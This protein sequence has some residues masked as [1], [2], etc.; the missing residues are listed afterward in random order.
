MENTIR[1]TYKPDS[2][3]WEKLAEC[4]KQAHESN[5]AQGINMQCAEFTGIELRDA[6]KNGITLVAQDDAGTLAGMLSVE[7]NKVN[8]WW[9]KGLGAY[10]CYVAV[11]PEF[12]G[13]GVYRALSE[14]A[15][16]IIASKGISVEYL[17]THIKNEAAQRAYIKDGYQKVRFSPGSGTDYYSVEM[18]KWLDG[19]GK[20]RTLCCL[21]YTAIEIAVRIV[22][23]PGKIRRFLL[24]L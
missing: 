7:F 20:S 17:N 11:A 8:R 5:K 24:F 16:E 6:V 19:K 10:I 3:S 1:V 9:H 21:M 4:Q 18:A 22:Y 13:R 2:I 12:K 15:N 23:K 14:K